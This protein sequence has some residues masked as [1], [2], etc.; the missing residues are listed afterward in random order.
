MGGLASN[1]PHEYIGREDSAAF[2]H[3][4]GVWRDLWG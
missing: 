1:V 2:S 4:D 3:P